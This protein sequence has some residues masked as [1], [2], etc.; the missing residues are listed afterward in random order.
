MWASW[1]DLGEAG[2]V[3]GDDTGLGAEGEVGDVRRPAFL[4]GE[5]V[6]RSEG[7]RGRGNEIESQQASALN[8]SGPLRTQHTGSSATCCPLFC[9]DTDH[10]KNKKRDLAAQNVSLWTRP[11]WERASVWA[12]RGTT[13]PQLAIRRNMF[14]P[15]S[16]A[17]V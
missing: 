8:L 3:M 1:W 9:H 17:N 10:H 6:V 13:Q 15:G 11:A 4:G 5:M 14:C 2:R 7:G 16:C 12:A